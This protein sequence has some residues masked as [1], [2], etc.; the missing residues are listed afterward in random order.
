MRDVTRGEKETGP[1]PKRE[2]QGGQTC[3]EPS[4]SLATRLRRETT[5]F[6]HVVIYTGDRGGPPSTLQLFSRSTSGVVPIGVRG[7]GPLG[8]E[9]GDGP[10]G[11]PRSTPTGAS[12]G[13]RPRGAEGEGGGR[14]VCEVRARSADEGKGLLLRDFNFVDN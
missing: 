10:R 6:A 14:N 1:G 4:S 8:D 2:S 5:V 13:R 7:R 9:T 11:A 12:Y 3:Q